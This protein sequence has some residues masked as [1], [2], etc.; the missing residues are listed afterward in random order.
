MVQG[1]V[2]QQVR[3]QALKAAAGIISILCHLCL[4]EQCQRLCQACAGKL[5]AQTAF[6]GLAAQK[7]RLPVHCSQEEI[8]LPFFENLAQDNLSFAEICLYKIRE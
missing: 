4:D 3:Q 2:P 8:R 7:F 6:L 1:G 5:V